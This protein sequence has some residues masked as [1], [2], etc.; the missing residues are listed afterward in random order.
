MP[1]RPPEPRDGQDGPPNTLAVLVVVLRLLD[2]VG[3]HLANDADRGDLLLRLIA[4]RRVIHR[5]RDH[6]GTL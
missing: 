5:L 4:T 2:D 3:D 1:T 6:L